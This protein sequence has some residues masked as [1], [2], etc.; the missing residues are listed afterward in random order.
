MTDTS[1]PTVPA[2]ADQAYHPDT[3]EAKWQARWA[4]RGTNEPDLDR[5]ARPFYNLMMFPYPSAEGLHVGNMFAFTGA[6]VYGRFKRLQGYDVFEPIGFD[7]FGIHSEN[8]AIKQGINPAILIPQNIENF[9]RQLRGI[10]GMFDWPHELSTTDPRYYKW[11]QWIFLQ[12]LKAGKAYKKAAAVNWCPKDKTVLAN[13]QVIDG[14]CERCGTVVEQRT[15]EQWFFRITEY[16]DRLLAD[17]DDES[18]MDWSDST[19][20]AQ[21]NWLGRSEG[22]E[23][24]FPIGGPADRRT[25]ARPDPPSPW[26][27]H[28]AS[29]TLGGPMGSGPQP[30]H[31]V[32]HALAERQLRDRGHGRC[33]GTGEVRCGFPRPAVPRVVEHQRNPSRVGRLVVQEEDQAIRRRAG[34]PT[35][36]G[37]GVERVEPAIAEARDLLGRA[38]VGLRATGGPQHQVG[39]AVVAARVGRAREAV[40][41]GQARYRGL[42]RAAAQAHGHG[43]RRPVAALQV[44]VP[45][46]RGVRSLAENV[47]A[48]DD[49]RIGAEQ[50]LDDRPDRRIVGDALDRRGEQIR[51]A[52]AAARL[53]FGELRIEERHVAA[54]LGQ[55]RRVAERE[56]LAEE[57]ALAVLA[58]RRERALVVA[59]RGLGH[60]AKDN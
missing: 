59:G 6:D 49:P 53:P 14:R 2:P 19:T 37:A 39:V 23:L 60:P 25:E 43:D 4:E 47:G 29:R 44:D 34:C 16:A 18:K 33:A 13:E 31:E 24:V 45:P 8:Y 17:L 38:A 28:S 7:A 51:H 58:S 3:V 1:K 26:T 50:R 15:L 56:R 40:R 42:R 52:G 12:L 5:A 20:T 32:E 54:Q 41:A 46:R 48:P 55:R 9:R 36:P 57:P 27:V 11:T 35:V 30:T 21:R 22:A 10:G